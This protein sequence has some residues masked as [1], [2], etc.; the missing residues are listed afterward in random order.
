[1]VPRTCLC[2]GPGALHGAPKI[3]SKPSTRTTHAYNTVLTD[4]L[5]PHQTMRKARKQAP[6]R[7]RL[8]SGP[9]TLRASP[10]THVCKRRRR[11]PALAQ[12]ARI[13]CRRNQSRR[14]RNQFGM[15]RGSFRGIAN[16]P[17]IIAVSFRGIPAKPCSLVSEMKSVILTI[18][19]ITCS[20]PSVSMYR[21]VPGLA[22]PAHPGIHLSLHI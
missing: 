9:S 17:L 7:P 4:T 20:P 5:P 19:I 22:H 18:K 21:L 11:H 12:R 13:R 10:P 1:M 15:V 2:I 8:P 3:V 16:S 14:G 6:R